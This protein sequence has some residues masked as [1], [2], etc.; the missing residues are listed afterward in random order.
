MSPIQKPGRIR[1]AHKRTRRPHDLAH[2]GYGQ[3]RHLGRML[4]QFSLG[5]RLWLSWKLSYLCR[6]SLSRRNGNN[7]PLPFFRK[8]A[9]QFDQITISP[10]RT[11]R[12]DLYR[13]QINGWRQQN[14]VCASKGLCNR[15]KRTKPRVQSHSDNRRVACQALYILWKESFFI[16]GREYVLQDKKWLKGLLKRYT[17]QKT[18]YARS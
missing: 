1:P 8:L 13:S 12:G 9:A 17:L 7:H 16:I 11:E 15:C 4:L 10:K 6:T 5:N 14:T 2:I 3:Q 18:Y